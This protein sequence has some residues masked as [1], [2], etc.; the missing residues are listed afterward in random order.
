MIRADQEKQKQRLARERE[1]RLRNEVI[2]A[3]AQT[4]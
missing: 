4:T 1:A 2:D 3:E